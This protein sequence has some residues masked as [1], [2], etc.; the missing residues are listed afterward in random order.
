MY[1]ITV[2][3][4][5][6]EYVLHNTYDEDFKVNDPVLEL[7]LNKSGTLTFS[8]NPDHPSRAQILPMASEIFVYDDSSIF[9]VGRPISIEGDF[10][11][12]VTVT[13]EG[14]LGYLLDT[15]VPPF[16]F[17][18]GSS[19]KG[20]DC[21]KQFLQ[22]L[23]NAHN[24]KVGTTGWGARKRFTVNNV[25]VLDSNNNLARSSEDYQST[26]ETIN[27]KLLQTHGGYIRVSYGTDKVSKYIDYVETY[28][29]ASQAITFGENL[30]DLNTHTNADNIYTAV[31]P[32]GAQIEGT[33]NR[34]TL[35]GYTPTTAVKNQISEY[36]HGGSIAWMNAASYF[37]GFYAIKDAAGVSAH[38]MI[39]VKQT[40]DDVTK[41]EN[42]AL[43]AAKWIG[44]ASVLG[45]K[46]EL[47]A[48]D[49][50]R[51]SVDYK[52]FNLGEM[53]QV[54]SIPHGINAEYQISK[55]TVDIA[56]PAGS[57]MVL[58][59]DLGTFTF[60]NTKQAAEISQKLTIPL[61]RS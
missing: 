39:L 49:L 36:T 53:V 23:I 22:R 60:E 33:D 48:V 1:S 21:I 50:S 13:C 26:L 45:T 25:T 42:L 3:N 56:N 24:T 29:A 20:S 4:Q 59:G 31:I 2:I 55:M 54:I 28:G 52:R 30:L 61:P 7:E 40:W 16:N 14:V 34:V 38:G 35:S 57:S 9:W 58:G 46:I 37:N 5:T 41:P 32:E 44:A 11:M 18:E 47:S 10:D 12:M 27:E 8:I 43:K 51:I 19:I 15:Q 6:G 17:T